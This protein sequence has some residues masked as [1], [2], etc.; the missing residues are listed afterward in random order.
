MSEKMVQYSVWSN[1]CNSCKFCLRRERKPYSLQK[2]IDMVNFIKE[3]MKYIDWKN[4]FKC[5]ISLLGGELY[6]ITNKELQKTFLSLIDDIIELVLKPNSS[7]YCRYSSVTNG[8]YE[9]TFLFNVIDKIKDS[10]G[11]KYVDLNF[12]Y[13]LKYRFKNEHDRLLC[14]ENINKFHERYNYITGVQMILTQ[15]FIDMIR[16]KEFDINTFLEKDIP[17]NQLSFLYPHPIHSGFKLKDFNFTRNDLLWFISYLKNVNIQVYNNFIYSTLNSGTFK[18]TGCK[19]REKMDL[20]KQQPIL[21]DGKQI[22]NEKCG[23]S[24]LYQCYSDS[25]KCMLCDLQM[26]ESDIGDF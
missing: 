22:I 2:Q 1:C 11:I 10:V 24:T 18:Y 21:T 9:P 12:S 14:L 15:Y 13:D 20:T 5:G 23:H 19:K 26:L 6:Y 7:D 17:G 4:E 25:D 8:L 3:N 16:N